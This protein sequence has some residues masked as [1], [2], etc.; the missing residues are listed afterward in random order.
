MIITQKQVSPSQSAL[1]REALMTLDASYFDGH[2]E[3]YRL[4][5]AQRLQWISQIALFVTQYCG[6]A[7]K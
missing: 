6:L 4:N 1:I 3:F 7:R 5:V 2:T